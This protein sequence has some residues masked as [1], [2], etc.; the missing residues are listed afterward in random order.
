MKVGKS[1]NLFLINGLVDGV[2]ACELLNWTGKGYKIPRTHLKELSDRTDLK[3]TGVY[4]LVGRDDSDSKTVYIGEAEEVYKRLL[5]HQDKDY[6][7]ECLV[8]I[9]KDDNL[10]K[11]HI[12][13]L[14]CM[15]YKLAIE[16]GRFKVLNNNMPNS[17]AISEADQAVMTE[18]GANLRVL[19]GALGYKIFYP[20]TSIRAQKQ[21][22]YIVSAV[23]GANASAVLTS[24]GMVVLK[25][26][27]IATSEVPSAP[28]TVV[29]KRADLKKNKV[30]GKNTFTKDYLFSS[31]SFAASVVMGRSANGL[32]EWKKTGGSTLKDNQP[33]SDD[34][35]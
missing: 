16:A 3:K 33:K 5:Q 24:E 8:F 12:K 25:G 4:F 23:R 34:E 6:W 35:G 10:N 26:S 15:L 31:P 13:Y 7:T 20:L 27:K 18:Y 2:V 9:S 30:V 14:E 19:V 11:A 21:D 22:R 17:P 29:E 32:A 28:K 1:I